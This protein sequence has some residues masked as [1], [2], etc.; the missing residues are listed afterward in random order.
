MKGVNLGGEGEVK[1]SLNQNLRVVLD[2]RWTASRTGEA[3][4]SLVKRGHAFVVSSNAELPFRSASIGQVYTNSVPLDQSTFLG[5]GVQT[6]EIRRILQDGGRWIDNG[7][8]VYVHDL[9]RLA[10]YWPTGCSTAPTSCSRALPF[11]CRCF[12]AATLGPR[13]ALSL[14][15]G[16]DPYR[17]SH[18]LYRRPV[19]A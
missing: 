6:S 1:G 5:P 9:R 17:G 7:M 8:L 18:V 14:N 10:P 19:A 2:E 15:R 16:A 3:L 13:R 11:T 4:T 12:A